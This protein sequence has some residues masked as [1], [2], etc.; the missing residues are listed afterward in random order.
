MSLLELDKKGRVTVPKEYR[1]ELGLQDKVLLV[2]AGDHLKLIPIPKDPIA[3][4][5]GAFTTR[6]PF[7][8][9]RKQ[10]EVEAE[11]AVRSQR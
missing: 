6:K 3:A 2:N 9:L 8:E 4:L 5:R 10:A 7:K 11:D 1:R